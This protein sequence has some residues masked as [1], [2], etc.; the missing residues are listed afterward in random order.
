MANTYLSRT[1]SSTGNRKTWTFSTWIKRGDVHSTYQ[2]LFSGYVDG[3]NFT[4]ILFWDDQR[5]TVNGKEIPDNA[6]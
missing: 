3:N 1:P 5:L 2:T 4:R 6:H